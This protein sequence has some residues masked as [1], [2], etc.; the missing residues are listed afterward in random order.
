MVLRALSFLSFLVSLDILP[1]F[2]H[3]RLLLASL[4]SLA[5]LLDITDRDLGRL[6]P[7]PRVYDTMLFS[8]RSEPCVVS[9][10]MIPCSRCSD[11]G[12][13]P[14]MKNFEAYDTG[15]CIAIVLKLTRFAEY[16]G[17]AVMA[18]MGSHVPRRVGMPSRT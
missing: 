9:F 3:L 6:Y 10:Q 17:L 1:H 15:I 11:D 2:H 5:H 13:S 12:I 16:K 14:M 8:Y 18:E 4:P 7:S